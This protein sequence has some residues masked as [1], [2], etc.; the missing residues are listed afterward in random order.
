EEIILAASGDMKSYAV[1][2]RN[3]MERIALSSR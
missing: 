3:E 2:K 1:K